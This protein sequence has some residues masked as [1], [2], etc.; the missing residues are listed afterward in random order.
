MCMDG[1]ARGSRSSS[2]RQQW[3]T[4]QTLEKVDH[5]LTC[6]FSFSPSSRTSSQKPGDDLLANFRQQFPEVAVG[7]SAAASTSHTA[8][9]GNAGIVPPGQERYATLYYT[10]L[11]FCFFAR[12]NFPT[13]P[14][15]PSACPCAA[16]NS[17][18]CGFS[19]GKRSSPGGVRPVLGQAGK[20]PQISFCGRFLGP[21][22]APKRYPATGRNR[23][24]QAPLAALLWL[25]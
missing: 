6:I 13:F 2:F 24:V 4:G 12:C 19:Q 14:S 1:M 17:Q 7:S 11:F 3:A 18:L 15:F 20:L 25:C 21:A 8:T 5:R 23:G 22:R 10:G 9:A 16:V